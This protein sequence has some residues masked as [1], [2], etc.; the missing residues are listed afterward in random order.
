MGDYY[1]CVL[2]FKFL[3]YNNLFFLGSDNLIVIE[4]G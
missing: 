3:V 4:L 1:G 2:R